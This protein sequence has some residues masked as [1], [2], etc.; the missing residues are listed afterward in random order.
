MESSDCKIKLIHL[1]I[2]YLLNVYHEQIYNNE[3]NRHSPSLS[4]WNL[5]SSGEKGNK[6]EIDNTSL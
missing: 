1:D 5:P 3:Q 4:S 6:L 2:D